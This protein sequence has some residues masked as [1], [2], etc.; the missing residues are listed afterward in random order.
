LLPKTFQLEEP[1]WDDEQ[2][3]FKVLDERPQ[4]DSPARASSFPLAERDFAE[5]HAR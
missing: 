2:A 1:T 5:S 3:W 4:P